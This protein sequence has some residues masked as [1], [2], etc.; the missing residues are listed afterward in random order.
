MSKATKN[1]LVARLV[2][3][4][5]VKSQNE[6]KRIID[7]VLGGIKEISAEQGGISLIGFGS[8][9]V[10][11]VPARSGKIPGTDKTYNTP[12]HKK[13]K[14]KPGKAFTEAVNK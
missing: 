5:D 6:A 8:F 12:A 4:G 2:E 1:D 7:L 10:A 14:F 13:V 11:D 3:R 9:A